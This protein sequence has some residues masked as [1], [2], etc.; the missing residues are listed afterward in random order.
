MKVDEIGEEMRDRQA[1]RRSLSL[2]LLLSPS[3]SM[4]AREA[5][6]PPVMHYML[7]QREGEPASNPAPATLE[8]RAVQLCVTLGHWS[9]SMPT[10]DV[11]GRVGAACQVVADH[12]CGR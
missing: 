2:E 11:F 9:W 7:P 3:E 8:H 1:E 10:P 4:T 12:L 6:R 5:Y